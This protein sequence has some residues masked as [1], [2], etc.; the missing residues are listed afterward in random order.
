MTLVFLPQFV[1]MFNLDRTAVADIRPAAKRS[2]RKAVVL[3]CLAALVVGALQT[4]LTGPLIY[5]DAVQKFP[6]YAHHQVSLD[7][8][9]V[10][11]KAAHCLTLCVPTPGVAP[12]STPSRLDRKCNL[13][14]TRYNIC[15]HC[16]EVGQQISKSFLLLLLLHLQPN[17]PEL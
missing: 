10:S 12:R 8:Q 17:F 2:R 4:P 1:T 13:C 11:L 7:H 9:F 16:I 14:P 6:Y 3:A 5:D 15:W